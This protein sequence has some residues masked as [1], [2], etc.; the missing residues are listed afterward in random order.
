MLKVA[1]VA[2][3]CLVKIG[4]QNGGVSAK[5]GVNIRFSHRDHQ[6]AHTLPERRLW[7]ILRKIRLGFR[8]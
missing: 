4:P 1:F 3:N 8:L 6:N 5:W 7:R 2:K